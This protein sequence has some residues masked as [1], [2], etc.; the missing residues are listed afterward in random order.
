MGA[1]RQPHKERD[2]NSR[3]ASLDIFGMCLV[4]NSL[5]F[6][7]ACGWWSVRSCDLPGP[8]RGTPRHG[9]WDGVKDRLLLPNQRTGD[10]QRA[11]PA[12]QAAFLAQWI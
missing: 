9:G 10:R 4:I 6:C 2:M 5:M 3:L 1:G 7:L 12:P 8:N 11:A